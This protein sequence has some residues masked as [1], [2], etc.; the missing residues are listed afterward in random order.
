MRLLAQREHSRRELQ[1]KL[2]LRGFPS[3]EITQ[4]LDRLRTQG[5]QS[6]SR[7]AENYIE[8]RLRRGFGPVRIGVELRERGIEEGLISEQMAI[9][10]EQWWEELQRVHQ[11]KYGSAPAK[12][13]NEL[14]KR[15]RFLEYRGFRGDLIRRLLFDA[16]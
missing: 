15:A 3:E 16:D 11:N 5:L 14:A 4:T 9:Y 6:D 7:F 10:K 8:S 2:R 1:D 12:S 13:R